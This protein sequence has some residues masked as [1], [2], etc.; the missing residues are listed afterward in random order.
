VFCLALGILSQENRSK[1]PRAND[2]SAVCYCKS[3]CEFLQAAYSITLLKVVNFMI[4]VTLFYIGPYVKVAL[5]LDP[6]SGSFI[7]Q[8]LLASFFGALFVAKAFRKKIKSFFYRLVG[9]KDQ[10]NP[11]DG[12]GDSPEKPR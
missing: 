5:Y 3:F 2:I 6:G 8:L 4:P 7:L 9:K 11:S 10:A 12:T 1:P